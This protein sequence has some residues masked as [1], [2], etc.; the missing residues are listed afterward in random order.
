ME[1][2]LNFSDENIKKIYEIINQIAIRQIKPITFSKICLE[3]LIRWFRLKI[4][5]RIGIRWGFE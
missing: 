1:Q 3:V 5:F 2:K 4:E